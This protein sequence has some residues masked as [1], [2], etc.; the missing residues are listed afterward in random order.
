MCTAISTNV[1]APFWSPNYS[2]ASHAGTRSWARED[3]EAG[4]GLV[5]RAETEEDRRAQWNRLEAARRGLPEVDLV[6]RPS[7]VQ[8][9][10]E[11]PKSV[12]ATKPGV[13]LLLTRD[14]LFRIGGHCH[15]P[16]R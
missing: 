4:D 15:E 5:R 12:L 7:A 2:Q 10:A 11:P 1:S 6:R 16:E 9:V 13:R 8:E 3:T 14:G